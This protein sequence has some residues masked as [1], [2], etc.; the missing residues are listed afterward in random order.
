MRSEATDSAWRARVWRKG[1]LVVKGQ[2]V[3]EGMKLLEVVCVCVCVGR[4]FV[5][6]CIC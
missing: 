2:L 6:V 5:C 3:R 4:T 1:Q